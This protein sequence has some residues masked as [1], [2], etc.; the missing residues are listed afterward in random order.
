MEQNVQD[1]GQ[2]TIDA[3][4]IATE[5]HAKATNHLQHLERLRKELSLDALSNQTAKKELTRVETQIAET[6]RELERSELAI[7]EAEERAAAEKPARRS[8]AIER[9]KEM[10]VE[11]DR[12]TASLIDEAK[13][14]NP[15]LV[16]VDE[17]YVVARQAYALFHDLHSASCGKSPCNSP[18]HHRSWN[19][20]D[21]LGDAFANYLPAP[22]GPKPAVPKPWEELLRTAQEG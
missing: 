14:K 2:V 18:G 12:T 19:L 1:S 10:L 22:A 6:K 20:R 7:E 13:R 9:M 15:D 16:N 8:A 21:R 11:F 17:I 3:L 4:H 5:A